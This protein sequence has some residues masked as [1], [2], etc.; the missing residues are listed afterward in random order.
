MLVQT[1]ASIYTTNINMYF[2]NIMSDLLSDDFIEGADGGANTRGSCPASHKYAYFNGDYCCH[3]NREKNS[4][5][6]N[7]EWK[8]LLEYFLWVEVRTAASRHLFPK[9]SAAV[10][11]VFES[12]ILDVLPFCYCASFHFQFLWLNF[13][14]LYP[15]SFALL[16]LNPFMRDKLWYNTLLGSA[17]WR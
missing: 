13:L 2:Q 17:L 10:P 16:L 7:H 9:K 1:N 3:Y 4:G 12:G 14:I 15:D 6:V 5:E 11:P 8:F